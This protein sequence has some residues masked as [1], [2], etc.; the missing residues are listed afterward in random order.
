MIKKI[1]LIDLDNTIINWNQGLK[2]KLSI[3][4]DIKNRKHWC[5]YKSFEQKL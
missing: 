5:I 3:D 4:L 1:I 2:D